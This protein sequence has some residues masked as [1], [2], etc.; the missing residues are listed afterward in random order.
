MEDWSRA[1][2]RTVRLDAADG[3][4]LL[5]WRAAGDG[6]FLVASGQDEETL[7]L[8]IC[9]RCHWI[10]HHHLEPDRAE[11]FV[12]CHNCGRRRTFAVRG[13]GSASLT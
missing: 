9:G 3:L 4:V 1:M 5:S 11:L 8:C 2:V 6:L 13:E 7:L 12:T 10:V